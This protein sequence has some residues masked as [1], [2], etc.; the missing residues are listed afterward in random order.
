M[1]SP[2][3][4][5]EP[6][7][8]PSGYGDVAAVLD[9][10]FAALAELHAL[11]AYEGSDNL[12]HYRAV[13]IRLPSGRRIGLL[14]HAGVPDADTEVHADSR[15]DPSDVLDEVIRTLGLRPTACS[16]LRRTDPA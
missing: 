4:Q 12:G 1:H 3:E 2:I 5:I 11:H 15:D 6:E 16:W 9:I 14:H 8:W 7:P 10:P 13:A